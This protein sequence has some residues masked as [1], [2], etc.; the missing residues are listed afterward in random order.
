MSAIGPIAPEIVK[1]LAD[2]NGLAICATHTSFDKLRG[3]LAQVIDEHQ[4]WDCR[5][6][7]LGAIPD[8]YRTSI[9]GYKKFAEETAA[10]AAELDQ[11]GLQF[12]Y[13]NHHFEFE[14]YGG[15]PSGMDTLLTATDPQT[16]GFELD[17]YW[18]QAAGADPEQW[19]HKVNGRMA[20]VHLK[21]MGVHQ[22]RVLTAEIGEG[23]MDYK[24][25]IQACRD[26]GVEWYV[27][28]Q[29]ECIRDPFESLAISY[30]NLQAFL[31]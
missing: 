3:S 8:A 27:V 5:Y 7:G 9:E 14:K 15:Q 28:E 12:I 21:D 18:I 6:V 25:L 10:I 31:D 20:V 24:K 17:L 1:E 22:G 30:R 19:I 13:H 4:L 11:A 23:N 16:F 29:D 26:T 2:E